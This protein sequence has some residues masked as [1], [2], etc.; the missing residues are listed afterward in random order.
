M[1]NKTLFQ[2]PKLLKASLVILLAA[3]PI[4]WSFAQFTFST[5]RTTLGQVIKTVQSQSK[6]QFF[7]DDQS[8]N[9]PIEN[10]EVKNVSLKQLL[11]AALKG[12]NLTYK[13]EDNIVYLSQAAKQ[14]DPAQTPVKRQ[15]SGTVDRKSV[16]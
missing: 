8:S 3:A 2:R 14:Q 9:M 10:L 5:P 16:V 13:I 6:Y 7:Y 4:Q 11:N 12:K 1:K 15:V